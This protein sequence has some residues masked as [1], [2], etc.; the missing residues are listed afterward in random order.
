MFQWAQV[1]AGDLMIMEL[2]TLCDHREVPRVPGGQADLPGRP[3]SGP[4]AGTVAV[5]GLGGARSSVASGLG[6]TGTCR[7][8]CTACATGAGRW[9]GMNGSLARRVRWAGATTRRCSPPTAAPRRGSSTSLPMR[10]GCR[11]GSR[12][13]PAAGL[14]AGAS[15]TARRCGSERGH[16]ARTRARTRPGGGVHRPVAG[17]PRRGRAAA[18][19]S[20]RGVVERAAGRPHRAGA[21]AGSGRGGLVADN[22]GG[23]SDRGRSAAR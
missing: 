6:E 13:G 16:R 20:R 23:V 7:G 17:F 21:R 9:S 15:L 2:L 18:G 14:S 1:A 12:C 19:A 5:S 10:P 22:G 11:S 8:V 4:P 3:R